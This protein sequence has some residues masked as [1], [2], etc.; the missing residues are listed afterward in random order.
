MTITYASKAGDVQFSEGFDIRHVE[1]SDN[2]AYSIIF[3]HQSAGDL[4][5]LEKADGG[6]VQVLAITAAD[7]RQDPVAFSKDAKTLDADWSGWLTENRETLETIA[8]E[9]LDP[10]AEGQGIPD[11]FFENIMANGDFSSAAFNEDSAL[12]VAVILE[13]HQEGVLS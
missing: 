3:K 9:V 2:G 11:N 6:A 12:A 5:F 7:S 13:A 10:M 1:T 4:I 8:R